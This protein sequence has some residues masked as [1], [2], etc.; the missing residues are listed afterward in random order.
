MSRAEE[1]RLAGLEERAGLMREALSYPSGVMRPD[2]Y[3]AHYDRAGVERELA[4]VTREAARIRRQMQGGRSTATAAP[5]GSR[6]S[7]PGHPTAPRHHRRKTL[8]HVKHLFVTAVVAA[9]IYFGKRLPGIIRTWHRETRAHQHSTMELYGALAVLTLLT[10]VLLLRT[11]GASKPKPA[12]RASGYPF[13]S[14]R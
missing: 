1:H 9:D 3:T 12:P 6:T 10:V 4:H 7:G 14:G 2:R 11:W 13:G 8:K 5:P